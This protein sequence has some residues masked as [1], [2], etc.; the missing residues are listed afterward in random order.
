MCNN[1]VPYN[2]KVQSSPYFD[3]VWSREVA[4]PILEGC[5]LLVAFQEVT[6]DIDVVIVL[7]PTIPETD[8]L[9]V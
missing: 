2:G 4:V 7:D 5:T 3:A 9:I 6:L 8:T 1:A